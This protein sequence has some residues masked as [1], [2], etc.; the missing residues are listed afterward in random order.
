MKKIAFV[1]AGFASAVLARNIVE[2]SSFE[3]VVFDSRSHI[4]GN[5]YTERE[6]DIM[7]HKYGPHIFNTS[8]KDVW[9]YVNSFVEFI[10]YINRVKA[11]IPK[12]IFSMPINLH[13]INQFFN[14]QFNPIEAKEFIKN[15]GDSNIENPSSFEE[16]ALK[17]IGK[18]LYD[19]FFKGYTK[20]Q[21][22]VEPKD[23]PASILKRL[24]VRFDYNDNYYN[25]KF[26]GIPINGYTD[27]INKILD[28]QKIKIKLNTFF[29]N[30]M[31]NDFDHV[32]YSGP[33]DK[34][35]NYS[36]GD[37]GYR[38]IRFEKFELQGD[39]QGNAVINYCDENIPFTRI[40]EH[41]HFTPWE[42]HENTICFKE[43][44]EQA[45][46]N[47]EPYYPVR[48]EKDIM[49]LKKYINLVN[50]TNK[51]TFIGRLGTYRYLDMHIVIEES[52]KL[53][54]ICSSTEINQW[55][56]FSNNPI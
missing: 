9:D 36:E 4:A 55:P 18:D 1:G 11:V 2:N 20:K 6:N 47:T 13:T 51:L 43:F 30:E 14:K 5:C 3:A 53:A 41:K 26:Q 29:T 27:L 50:S 49:I 48:L 42:Q 35:F 37:L 31:L 22:G 23:L 15:I 33:L 28:H 32:F 10:P 54:K 38:T 24:P 8:N 19:S 7:I 21:W 16:T 12:G 56:K 52:L 39:Y 17:M 44:S 45:D 40:T 34:F 25:Q 46:R